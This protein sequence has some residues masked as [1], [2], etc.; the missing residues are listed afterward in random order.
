MSRAREAGAAP[1]GPSRAAR[2]A[3]EPLRCTAEERG[4]PCYARRTIEIRGAHVD[5][6]AV[7]TAENDEYLDT[8]ARALLSTT[9][10]GSARRGAKIGDDVLVFVARADRGHDARFHH[11]RDDATAQDSVVQPAQVGQRALRPRRTAAYAHMRPPAPSRSLPGESTSRPSHNL[12]R[13]RRSTSSTSNSITRTR[14]SRRGG[15]FSTT[16]RPATAGRTSN[17]SSGAN[18]GPRRSASAGTYRLAFRY[19]RCAPR[20]LSAKM[21][22]SGIA[23]GETSNRRRILKAGL[24]ASTSTRSLPPRCK[25]RC[26]E[27][28]MMSSAGTGW[29]S[30][31]YAFVI[32]RAGRGREKPRETPGRRVQEAQSSTACMYK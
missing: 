14:P 6:R 32:T 26:R 23:D 1:A 30:S 5:Q 20:L 21:A 4:D 15:T 13:A 9:A 28:P 2:P 16:S 29:M 3:S 31:I 18:A 11:H 7:S 10:G 22:R 19:P 25:P 24:L 27:S 12:R 17:P 8:R